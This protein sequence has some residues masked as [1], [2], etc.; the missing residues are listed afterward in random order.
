MNES[1]A[2]IYPNI[3]LISPFWNISRYFLKYAN[4]YYYYPK[5]FHTYQWYIHR[6]PARLKYHFS[7]IP[8]KIVNGMGYIFNPPHGFIK[9]IRA[10][11]IDAVIITD[12]TWCNFDLNRFK[13]AIRI[14]WSWDNIYRTSLIHDLTLIYMEKFDYV[15]S[16]HRETVNIFSE[17]GA[18]AFWLPYFYDPEMNFPM[19]IEK[20]IDVS[21]VGNIYGRRKEYIS[22]LKDKLV[23]HSYFFGNAYQKDQNE[24]YNRSKIV[25]NFPNV[26]ELNQRVFEALG[27]GS[28]LL[29]GESKETSE[30]FNDKEDLV[31]YSDAEDLLEKINYFLSRDY[32]RAN[33]SSNGHLKV[34]KHHTIE[35]RIV[36][37]LN[38]TGLIKNNTSENLSMVGT[39]VP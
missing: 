8:Q 38:V 26:G 29:T 20:S 2:S 9:D 15:F 24:I 32:E 18:K 35:S 6:V 34:L 36:D 28:F 12:P 16:A 5:H 1:E 17:T 10:D 4:V 31:Y 33:I 21:F 3:L 39:K 7:R 30:I 14:Y 23:N 22:F 11:M 19:N 27:S 13:N 25:I 37:M